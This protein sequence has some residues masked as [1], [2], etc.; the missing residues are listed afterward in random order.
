MEFDSHRTGSGQGATVTMS[1]TKQQRRSSRLHRAR[2]GQMLI[3]AIAILFVLLII[4]G[5]FVAQIGRNLASAVRGK[6]NQGAEAYAEAGIRYADASFTLS[7]EGADWRPQ[8]YQPPGGSN[9]LI[10]PDFR[11][12]QQGFTRLFFQGGRALIRVV[13]DPHA[14]DPRSQYLRIESVGRAGD[15]A[16][17]LDP[18]VFT[19]NGN[20]PRQRREL[21]AYKQ[22]GLTDYARWMTNKDHR[23]ISNFLGIPALENGA[24]VDVSMVLGDPLLADPANSGGLYPPVTPTD[25]LF[26]APIRSNA[27]LRLG[28]EI[29]LFE[30][31]RGGNPNISPETIITAGDFITAPNQDINGDGVITDADHQV[32]VNAPLNATALT[33]PNNVLLPSADVN[34]LTIGGVARDQRTTPDKIGI[35]RSIPFLDPPIMDSYVS[36]TG[37]LLYRELTRLSG[38]WNSPSDNTGF[39]GWGTGTYIDNTTDLQ[40]ETQNATGG[41]SL[42]ADW[43]NPQANFAQHYWSGAYYRPP[44]VLIEL[45]GDHIHLTRSD[46]KSFRK[47]D[48]AAVTAGG[49]NV[50]DIP[51]RNSDRANYTFG[52]GSVF[53]LPELAHDG[54]EAASVTR[55]PNTANFPVDRLSYGV[56]MVIMAEGN[57]RVK[58]VYGAISD[59]T[60]P[61]GDHLS[62]V[63]LTI[64]SGGTAY[65]DGNILKGDGYKDNT[66]IHA[67]NASSCAILAK[68]YVTINTTMFMA[69]ENQ[70]PSW[71]PVL[72]NNDLQYIGIP[73]D[74]PA[75]DPIMAFGVDPTTYTIG[76]G[77]GRSPLFLLMRHA[78]NQDNSGGGSSAFNLEI[79]AATNVGG[80]PPITSPTQYRFNGLGVQLPSLGPLFPAETYVLG[81]KFQGGALVPDAAQVNPNFEQKAFPLTGQVLNTASGPAFTPDYTN[82][83]IFP[84][85]NLLGVGNVF[86]FQKDTTA[87]GDVSQIGT[88]FSETEDYLFSGAMVAPLDIK[89]QALLYAQERSFFVIPGYSFNQNPNDTR[90]NF[91]ITG[92][93]PI[94][95]AFEGAP[96]R[97]KTVFPFYNEPMDV[98]ITIIGAVTENYTASAGD[99]AAWMGKWGYIHTFHGSSDVPI[100][101]Q[102]MVPQTPKE[103][104][105]NIVRGL[106]FQ[107]DPVLPLPYNHAS[108][109]DLMGTQNANIQTRQYRSVRSKYFPAA[110][111]INQTFQILPSVPRLPVCPGLLYFGPPDGP[112][113]P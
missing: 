88:G 104:S 82:T 96:S 26:G 99:Q 63:H 53:V 69:A 13:Y 90:T 91:A 100:P 75:Y 23:S 106:E 79:N 33:N 5:I 83:Q 38:K 20:A 110:G 67:E 61:G 45:M 44:G 109:T 9:P 103:I 94:Y 92:T 81:L 27:T 32:L 70:G 3:V 98:K 50:V 108:G 1:Q 12:L 31:V 85:L 71:T 111:Q 51:L 4:G 28:G 55:D 59:T 95:D 18:T 101:D 60:N 66:G 76:G 29:H 11:W 8:P 21:V 77:A 25:V 24:G 93:R 97:P 113:V 68:D 72:T 34:F 39:Y 46:G 42:R 19:S 73:T 84:S 49:G 80:F 17:G 35:S 36:G 16:Q 30:S 6:E 41:Y 87:A 65:I 10:D 105:E 47:P 54:D 37:S 22:I 40:Q 2:R 15:L 107:Y 102:H 78:S 64:V 56:N 89:I 7:P 52:D 74:A 58:G 62:R 14:D 57:V 48:G 86:H 112:V 43:L